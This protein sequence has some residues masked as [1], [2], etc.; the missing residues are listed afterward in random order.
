MGQTLFPNISVEELARKTVSVTLTGAGCARCATISSAMVKLSRRNFIQT[1]SA[2]TLVAAA[3]RS[4]AAGSRQR[5]FIGSNTKEGILAYDW[6]PATAELTPAGV[7]AKLANVD[8]ITFS[9][10]RK[11]LYA[12]SEVDT[13]N[14]K[15]TGG[16]ASFQVVN[17]N[18]HP[19][20][21]QNSASKG[22]CH[23]ALDRTGRVL[24]SAD[25]GGGSADTFL[26]SDG[27]LSETVWTEHY[28]GH[29][30]VSDRQQTAHAH[31]AS[32]SPDNRF[33]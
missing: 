22:T 1:A 23:V 32:F 19:L 12:A 30:P 28:T 21:A 31:F 11:F 15:P 8:W 17:G 29:G 5:V 4:L 14:G 16:V 3:S 6:D 10:D 25:Y 7:A 18:L 9:P 20:S 2:A 27:Q 13:F 26:V 24:L 33:A